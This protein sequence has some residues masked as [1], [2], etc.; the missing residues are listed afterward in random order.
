MR[1]YIEIGPTPPEEDCA[2][3]G[4]E[5]YH[6]DSRKEC[7]RYIEAIRKKLGNEPALARLA[8][9]VFPHDFGS[10]REV[11]CY[12]DD[13]DETAM[14]YAFDCESNGPMTWDG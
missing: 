2:Q 1:D 11:V 10:Y 7:E 6:K 4:T 13:M 14:K 12:Y 5:N 9:K 8:I 3:V